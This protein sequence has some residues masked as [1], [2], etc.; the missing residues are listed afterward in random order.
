MSNFMTFEEWAEQEGIE[1]GTWTWEMSK[2]GWDARQVEI[3][4]LTNRVAELEKSGTDRDEVDIS[5]EQKKIRDLYLEAS[6][7]RM[8]K[9][10]L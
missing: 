7:K 9:A 4:E 10:L 2:S 1:K 6:K 3:D 8:F 5:E